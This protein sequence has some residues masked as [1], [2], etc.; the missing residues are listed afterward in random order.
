MSGIQGHRLCSQPGIQHSNIH[1]SHSVSLFF[2]FLSFSFLFFSFLFFSCLVLSCLVFSFLFFF[3][4]SSLPYSFIFSLFTFQML[5]PFTISHLEMLYPIF[6][7][8][9]SM[10]VLPH[11]LTHSCLPTL[12]FPYTGTSSLHSTRGLSSH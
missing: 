7:P 6:L 3:L 2:P 10:K 12:K 8:P 11:P 1:K 9:A 4:F 5:S